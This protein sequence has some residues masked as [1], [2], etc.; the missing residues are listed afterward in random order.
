MQMQKAPGL[1]FHDACITSHPPS[2]VHP[3]LPKYDTYSNK[4]RLKT[5]VLLEPTGIP[6]FAARGLAIDVLQAISDISD[7]R[8][9]DP[10]G[11]CAPGLGVFCE[12]FDEKLSNL[13][14]TPRKKWKAEKM[15]LRIAM[16]LANFPPELSYL[17]ATT[18][19]KHSFNNSC[20]T[21]FNRKPYCIQ[22][23]A[24]QGLSNKIHRPP[25]QPR[26]PGKP[27][28]SRDSVL[29]QKV[30]AKRH[31]KG[32]G[33]ANIAK[34]PSRWKWIWP[35]WPKAP[36]SVRIVTLDS[37][38]FVCEAFSVKPCRVFPI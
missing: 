15:A 27:W 7:S 37:K 29:P 17:L 35:N 34:A 31:A 22:V 32:F 18:N 3:H 2:H 21:S 1:D 5:V 13:P 8:H 12:A 30:A 9:V 19:M 33:N 36:I 16:Q 4:I 28:K 10:C 25:M 20:N 26:S 38:Q 14:K 24:Q 11:L 23:A 6:S